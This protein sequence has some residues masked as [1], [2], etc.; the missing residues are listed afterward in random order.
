MKPKHL[1]SLEKTTSKEIL[2]LIQLSRK[3]KKNPKA[4]ENKLHR[5]TLLMLFEKP[6]LRTHLSFEVAAF[7]LGGHAI[8]FD[9][10]EAPLGKGKESIADT[11]KTFSHYIDIVVARLFEHETLEKLANNSTVPVINGL[12]NFSH[13]CQILSD[14]LT[15]HE[16]F[17][18]IKNLKLTY[19]GDANNNI[20]HSLLFALPKMGINLTIICPNKKEFLP[21]PRVI[22]IAKQEA[23]KNNTKIIVTS[24]I[25][26]AKNSDIIY[27]DSWMS[28][29]IPKSQEKARI[30]ALKKYQVN[31]KLMNLA[32]KKEKTVFMHCL[33]ATREQEV[34][35]EVIDGKQSIVFT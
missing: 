18:K 20:V 15:I 1:L 19:I 16:H 6:S 28:Y 22:S 32:G 35:N 12:T 10:H 7:Q 34:T 4:F 3:I 9:L 24:N 23:K 17:G 11:A 21:H 25:N 2:S 8:F 26:E 5:K 13:P 29:H 31:K 30:L 33:P 14:L 27:T